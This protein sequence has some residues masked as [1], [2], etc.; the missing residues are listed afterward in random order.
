VV[1]SVKQVVTR[2]LPGMAGASLSFS[3]ERA[4][5]GGKGHTCPNRQL[6]S[7]GHPAHEPV[8]QLVVLS[9]QVKVAESTHTQ[10][11]RLTLDLQGKLLKLAVSR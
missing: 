1:A 7:C 2:Y 4:Q 5:C 3:Q 10:Y 6:K 11:A 9:K 8:R